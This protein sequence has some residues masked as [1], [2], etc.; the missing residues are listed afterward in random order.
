MASESEAR[1]KLRLALNNA[2]ADERQAKRFYQEAINASNASPELSPEIA[3]TRQRLDAALKAAVKR[4]ESAKYALAEHDKSAR[5]RQKK[6]QESKQKAK[7][8]KVRRSLAD[9]K[10]VAKKKK[11]PPQRGFRRRDE[12]DEDRER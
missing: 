8:Q 9:M 6:E 5:E 11:A 10:A 3:A 4:V 2:I 12:Q 7:G 1:S